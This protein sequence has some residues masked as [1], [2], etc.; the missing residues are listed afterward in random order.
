MI[1]PQKN[2]YNLLPLRSVV[3]WWYARKE[4]D[5]GKDKVILF[6]AYNWI[7]IVSPEVCRYLFKLGEK[8][9]KDNSQ[10]IEKRYQAAVVFWRK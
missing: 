9:D 10:E 6:G 7:N 3:W 8:I 1:S 5:R 2:W 4:R